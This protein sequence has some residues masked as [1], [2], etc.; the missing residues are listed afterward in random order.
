MKSKKSNP[1]FE[2]DL[3]I[4][5]TLHSKRTFF[6]SILKWL[7]PLAAFGFKLILSLIL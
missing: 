6:G 7:I 4:H 2:L 1:V 3:K 5:L